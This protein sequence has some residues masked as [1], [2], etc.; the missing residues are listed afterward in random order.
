[1]FWSALGVV[2]LSLVGYS[3]GAVLVARGREF[4][5]SLLDLLVVLALWVAAFVVRGQIAAHGWAVLVALGLGLVVGLVLTAARFALSDAPPPMPKS[6]LPEHAQEKG[7]TA[8]SLSLVR[9][10]WQKWGEFGAQLG[11][12]QGRL[13]MGFFYFIFVTP[14]AL[15]FKLLSDPLHMKQRPPSTTWMAKDSLDTTIT[16]A[17]EQ[18]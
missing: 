6:E 14:F 12:V 4:Y 17:R 9:R 15:G 7:G 13:L 2:L 16:T 11:A 8:V 1:M 18:G 3:A 10:L 5:P